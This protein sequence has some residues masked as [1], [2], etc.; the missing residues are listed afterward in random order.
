MQEANAIA[1]VDIKTAEVT[2]LF[3]LGVKDH[4]LVGNELDASNRDDRINIT[5]WPVSGFYMPDA[6]ASY[7]FNDDTYLVTAN[8]GDSRDYDGYSDEAR[9]KDLP[10]DPVAFPDA[11][12]LQADE[13]LGRLK[14]TTANGDSDGDGDFDTL[15]S[16]GARSFAIWSEQGELIFDSGADFEMI[17]GA[18]IP[19]DFNSTSDENGSFDNRS[20]DKGPEPE[21]IALGRIKGHTI[22]FIGLERIGGIMAY[23]ITNPTA[24]KFLSYYNNR[25]FSA[26]VQLPDKSVN[27]A[28]G[29]LAPEGLVFIP[30]AK[31]PNG[32]PLLV[33]G[34]EVSGTTTI[35]QVNYQ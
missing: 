3:P 6:I 15:Y 22:A 31:S 12:N 5:N 28:V 27:P 33:T 7:Q 25:D 8:E 1:V 9:V 10:L 29:D 4:N 19:A 16:Y 11:E 34:N 30:A 2:D 23:D 13:N 17:T 14:V 24:V 32:K 20:D 21:G 35:F 18:M 26:D